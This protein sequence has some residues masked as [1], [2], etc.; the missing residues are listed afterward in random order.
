MKKDPNFEIF[1][2]A[3]TAR[4][5]VLDAIEDALK[6]ISGNIEKLKDAC[7]KLRD[8]IAGLD[9]GEVEDEYRRFNYSASIFLLLAQWKNAIRNAE[10]DSKRY[11]N[12]A[13]LQL[14]ELDE[15]LTSKRSESFSLFIDRV[16]NLNN[17]SEL[18]SISDLLRSWNLPLLLYT[19]EKTL[20]AA[21]F[22][23]EDLNNKQKEE[24]SV[25][26]LKFDID[27]QPAQ[28]FNYLK[29]GT[30]YDLTIEV[31]VSNWPIDATELLLAPV[32]IDAKERE[33]LPHFVFKKPVGEGQFTLRDTGRAVLEVAH[34]FGSRPYEFLYAAEFTGSKHN[35]SVKIIGHRRLLLE[36]TDLDANPVS[37]FAHVDKHLIKI[38][39]HLR[40]LRVNESDLA[41]TM[42]ALGGLGNIYAQSLKASTFKEKTSEKEFQLKA[43]E[44]LSNRTDIGEKLHSHTEASG[45][46]TDLTFCDIPIELK[47]EHK[48]T[49]LPKD[50]NKYFNQTASYANA[51]G[52]KIGILAVLESS[53]KT[54]PFGDVEDDFEVFSHPNGNSN[55]VIVVVVVRGGFPKPSSYSR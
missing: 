27:G 51:L 6:P 41:N 47:V 24:A 35:G 49:L 43:F 19:N 4:V 21:S 31:R 15:S 5:Q 10:S 18:E 39:N 30:S 46:I 3:L 53:P 7:Y 44:L 17:I 54:A 33:W 25:A 55:T 11:L 32:T 42:T 40:T 16:N 45:G 9:R 2:Q 1:H 23:K 52:K 12:S 26:F 8:L 20:S 13:Q 48:K 14:S 34:S 38:R 28:Q 29:P 37:G 36:G 22:I 50:F